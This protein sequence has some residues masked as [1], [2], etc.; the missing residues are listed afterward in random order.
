MPDAVASVFQ[1]FLLMTIP[2]GVPLVPEEKIS[3]NVESG[4]DGH[5]EVS[6][7]T[8]SIPVPAPVWGRKP[9]CAFPSDSR[10]QSLITLRDAS[11]FAS[12]PSGRTLSMTMMCLSRGCLLAALRKGCSFSDVTNAAE[13]SALS[14]TDSISSN[15]QLVCRPTEIKSLN[16]HAKST[17]THAG[18]LLAQIP[19]CARLS[20]PMCRSPLA[21]CETCSN[22]L[23][24]VSHSNS[25]REPIRR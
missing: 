21:M 11:F 14:T 5:R 7:S 19:T 23:A 9:G 17:K 3:V 16:A 22:T 25:D 6:S 8:S 24:Y 2:F 10:S 15:G 18:Q 12:Q 13:S 20:I 4:C 1:R